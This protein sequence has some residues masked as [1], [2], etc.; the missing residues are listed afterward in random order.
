[1][2]SRKPRFGLSF[3]DNKEERPCVYGDDK[4]EPKEVNENDEDDKVGNE[5]GGRV[6]G[7][8]SKLLSVCR[9]DLEVVFAIYAIDGNAFIKEFSLFW[10]EV[11]GMSF[12]EVGMAMSSL[13]SRPEGV[14]I[15]GSELSP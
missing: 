9:F 11:T 12:S 13:V 14:I 6:L 1:M 4:D 5:D 3:K 15:V 8:C 2:I 10:I 7:G